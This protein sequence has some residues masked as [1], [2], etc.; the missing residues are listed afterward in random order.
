ML[1]W[2][3]SPVRVCPCMLQNGQATAELRAKAT[4]KKANARETVK[5]IQ[6]RA[7]RPGCK[8]EVAM[9]DL[10][11]GIVFSGRRSVGAGLLDFSKRYYADP[12]AIEQ[13]GWK[14]L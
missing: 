5:T 3:T 4:C 12:Q 14:R 6:N 8:N 2:L 10:L 9:K 13:A 1:A 7:I 11:R